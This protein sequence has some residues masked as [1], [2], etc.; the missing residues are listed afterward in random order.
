MN[1]LSLNLQHS[2]E[3]AAKQPMCGYWPQLAIIASFNDSEPKTG[4]GEDCVE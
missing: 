4:P 3:T 2:I 1:L